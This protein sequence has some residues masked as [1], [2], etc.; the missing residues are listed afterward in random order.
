MRKSSIVIIV[1]ICGLLAWGCPK[2]PKEETGSTPGSRGDQSGQTGT[3][4]GTG[5]R[6]G[7]GGVS[8]EELAGQLRVIYFDFDQ[9]N[10][11]DD[12]RRDLDFNAE[13]LKQNPD[14]VLVIEGHCDERGTNE[15]NLALGERRAQAAK[16]Y[17]SRLGVDASR[18]SIISYGE[19]RPSAMGHDEAA[20]SKNRRA[21][22]VPR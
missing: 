2:P 12:A 20:W 22:F 17:L 7:G 5:E 1:A 18:L 15:Y 10:L 21:E 16:D 14:A 3:D 13:V 11:R 9:Y 6:P 19:E 8:S 4:T